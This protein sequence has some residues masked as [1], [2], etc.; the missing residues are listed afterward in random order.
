MPKGKGRQGKGADSPPK[1]VISISKNMSRILRHGT[2]DANEM[3]IELDLPS[4]A[5]ALVEDLMAHDTFKRLSATMDDVRRCAQEK[6]K[7]H[8]LRFDLY[9]SHDGWRIRAFQGHTAQASAVPEHTGTLTQ[10]FV[11]HATQVGS[12]RLIANEGFKLIKGR[13][14]SL[15][16]ES[17]LD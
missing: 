11:I 9:E 4:G 7:S 3:P 15:R 13:R 8:K 2:D 1:R 5:S 14:V 10:R 17:F 6:D 12:A 16:R